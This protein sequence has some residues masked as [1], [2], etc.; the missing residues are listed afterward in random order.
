M[1][2]VGRSWPLIQTKNSVDRLWTLKV[3]VCALSR[4]SGIWHF[5]TLWTVACWAPVSMGFS[6]QEYWSGLPCPPPED[7]PSPRIKPRCPALQL[8]SSSF[9]LPRNRPSR[10]W[11]LHW[12]VGSWPLGRLGSPSKT[13]E[14][15][16]QLGKS[17]CR[18]TSQF[19]KSHQG[20]PTQV[21]HSRNTK[22]FSEGQNWPGVAHS[23]IFS[24]ECSLEEV[25][26]CPN[27]TCG[28]DNVWWKQTRTVYCLITGSRGRQSKTSEKTEKLNQED[29][30]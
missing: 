6:R 30:C 25:H 17:P 26:Q 1:I 13:S 29:L 21:H 2:S 19:L 11:T 23:T 4:F 10:Y 15:P 20:Y 28:L 16:D 22:S 3:R 24:K 18:V 8:N 9:E 7:F 12:Q 14:W 27:K 5:A